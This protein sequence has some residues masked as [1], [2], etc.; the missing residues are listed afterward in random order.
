MGLKTESAALPI[1]TPVLNYLLPR[2]FVPA[3]WMK[4]V[5]NV[6]RLSPQSQDLRGLL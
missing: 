2:L 6:L 5:S 3:A 4:S 1:T